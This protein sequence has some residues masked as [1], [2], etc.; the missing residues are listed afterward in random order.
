MTCPSTRIVCL[1][2]FAFLLGNSALRAEEPDMEAADSPAPRAEI[3]ARCQQMTGTYAAVAL[4]KTEEI[5]NIA[6]RFL[7]EDYVMGTP[8]FTLTLKDGEITSTGAISKNVFSMKENLEHADGY[9]G[10]PAVGYLGGALSCALEFR[11]DMNAS[12]V[13]YVTFSGIR[14]A[15]ISLPSPCCP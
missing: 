4:V 3:P 2:L 8:A 11:F 10:F 1:A 15:V 5:K 13:K 9:V 12:C 14:K 7:H 6:Q